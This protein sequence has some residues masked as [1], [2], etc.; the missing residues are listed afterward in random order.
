MT[1][2]SIPASSHVAPTRRQVVA[3][4]GAA[5]LAGLAVSRNLWAL[6]QQQQATKEAP[7]TPANQ[8]RTS[9]HQE[10]ELKASPQRIYEILLDSKQFAAFTGMPANIDS[11]VGG[12]FS[13]FGG[14][15]VGRNVELIPNQRIVQAWRPTH[16]DPGVYSLVKFE[17]KPLGNGTPLILDHTGFPEGDYDSLF[18]GWTVRYWDPLKKYLG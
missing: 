12:A 16:W 8:A 17:L 3:R 4:V 18:H 13:M 5:A 11:A 9:R 15:I 10:I 14:M 2:R 7:S 6:P 1:E